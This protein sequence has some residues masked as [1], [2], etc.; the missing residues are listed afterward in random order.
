MS[1]FFS[2][3]WI[4]WM[5]TMRYRLG[6]RVFIFLLLT[7]LGDKHY[8]PHIRE[9]ELLRGEVICLRSHSQWVEGRA[10]NPNDFVL[11]FWFYFQLL[12]VLPGTQQRWCSHALSLP[13]RVQ[14]DRTLGKQAWMQMGD[15]GFFWTPLYPRVYTNTH[16]SRGNTGNTTADGD[17]G[18]YTSVSRN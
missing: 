4:Y 7:M 14:G 2:V 16:M 18:H 5:R 8:Q 15:S 12:T 10:G 11:F 13:G 9:A 6:A 17:W 3:P 1:A